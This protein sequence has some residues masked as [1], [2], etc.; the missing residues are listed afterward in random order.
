MTGLQFSYLATRSGRNHSL[1]FNI[2]WQKQ[3]ETASNYMNS[4]LLISQIHSYLKP[5]DYPQVP[6]LKN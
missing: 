1:L 2:T 3:L 5:S 4:L 6:T